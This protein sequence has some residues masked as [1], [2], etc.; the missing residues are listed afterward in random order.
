MRAHTLLGDS[1]PGKR[2]EI[3]EIGQATREGERGAQCRRG[4]DTF[5]DTENKGLIPERKALPL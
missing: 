5:T 1:S 3:W 4:N 2:M